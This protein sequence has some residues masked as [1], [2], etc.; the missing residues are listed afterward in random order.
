M[1]ELPTQMATTRAGESW[2]RKTWTHHDLDRMAAVGLIG[3][4][5]RVELVEGEIFP[6]PAK[7]QRHERVRLMLNVWLW[8]HLGRDKMVL[9]EAGWRPALRDY[10]EPDFLIVPRRVVLP[11]FPVKF[12]E[13]RMARLEQGAAA[14]AA[15]VIGDRLTFTFATAYANCP[16]DGQ[17]AESLLALVASRL[18]ELRQERAAEEAVAK[19]V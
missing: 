4:D 9:P 19:L 8:D 13:G 14:A 10:L 1:T 16:E 11:E 7:G 2:P 12:L 6:M 3:P 15:E 17:D 5:E 18:H